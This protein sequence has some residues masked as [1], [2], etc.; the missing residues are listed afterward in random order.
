MKFNKFET[1]IEETFK[2]RDKIEEETGEK[3]IYMPNITAPVSE[4]KKR[5]DFVIN[6]GGEYVMLDIITLGFSALQEIRDHLEDKNVV[7]CMLQLQ[8]TRNMG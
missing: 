8:D 4:M 3:K 6:Y 7:T 2:I 1:R 5:A